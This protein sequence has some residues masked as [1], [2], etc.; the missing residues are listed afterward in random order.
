MQKD[1]I[2]EVAKNI[3]TTYMEGKNDKKDILGHTERVVE[4]CKEFIKKYV[5]KHPGKIDGELLVASAWLHDIA[6]Y[7]AKDRHNI[8]E[9]VEAV[10]KKCDGY[11]KL[12]DRLQ[13]IL[14][15]ISVHK[16]EFEPKK[17]IL[18][19]AVLRLCDKMDRFDEGKDDAQKKC[20]KSLEIFKKYS[21]EIYDELENF[22]HRKIKN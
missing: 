3:F 12:S 13:D 6:R 20:E 17:N 5:K 10:L 4:L 14:A 9:K 11:D 2:S 15:I 1:Q 16:D 22:Y 19:C 21:N 18:E 8:P 7:E